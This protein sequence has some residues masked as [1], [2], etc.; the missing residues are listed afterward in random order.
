MTLM[1]VTER[2]G[3]RELRLF[4][5]ATLIRKHREHLPDGELYEKAARCYETLIGSLQNTS[6]ANDLSALLNIPAPAVK[7]GAEAIINTLLFNELQNPYL[8]L[9][10]RNGASF[11]EV[12]RRWKSL[13]VLYHPDKVQNKKDYEEKAKKINELY[14]EIRAIQKQKHYPGSLSTVKEIRVSEESMPASYSRYLPSVIFTLAIIAA[15]FSVLLFIIHLLI[16]DSTISSS[17]ELQEKTEIMIS[18][19]I[20]LS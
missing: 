17:S 19:L 13:L 2:P 5:T 1:N 10:L 7:A 11:P 15:I 18:S 6:V 20:I 9:G 3:N 12:T 16:N 8:S 4:A 14:E